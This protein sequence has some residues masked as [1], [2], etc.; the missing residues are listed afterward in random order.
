MNSMFTQQNGDRPSKPNHIVIISDGDYPDNPNYLLDLWKASLQVRNRNI[1]IQSVSSQKLI[2]LE[3]L[4]I[5]KLYRILK[6]K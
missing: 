6:P 4:I 2:F 5:N 1:F 3:K